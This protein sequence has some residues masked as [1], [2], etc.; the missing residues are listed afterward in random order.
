[1]EDAET[2][3]MKMMNA[4]LRLGSDLRADAEKDGDRLS[5]EMTLAQRRDVHTRLLR[6]RLDMEVD[7]ADKAVLLFES[8]WEKGGGKPHVDLGPKLWGVDEP[9]QVDNVPSN[10]GLQAQVTLFKLRYPGMPDVNVLREKL[11]WTCQ[12]MGFQ[13]RHLAPLV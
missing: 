2:L 7:E 13:L 8:L 10:P 6:Y 12:R 9:F 11:K 5:L 3:G 4:L 1:V